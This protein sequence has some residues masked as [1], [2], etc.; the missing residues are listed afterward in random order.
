MVKFLFGAVR[1]VRWAGVVRVALYVGLVNL[2]ISYF[3]MHSAYA[4]AERSVRRLGAELTKQM[5]GELV[6]EPQAVSV[7]GQLLFLAAKETSLS[8]KAVLDRF[9]A[10]CEAHSG[11]LREQFE[12]IPGFAQRQLALPV[13]V[14]DPGRIGI[15]R[16]DAG[17]ASDTEGEAH[18]VCIAQP[19]AA[20]GVAGVVKRVQGFLAS[21]DVSQIGDMRYIA[22]RKMDDGRTQVIAIWTEGKFNIEAMFPD[23]GDVPGTDALD[24]PRPPA[25]VR[26]LSAVVPERPYAIRSYDSTL[27]ARDVLSFYDQKLNAAGWTTRPSLMD[28]NGAQLK[29]ED[30]RA[31]TRDGRALLIAATEHEPGQTSVT[32]IELG[33]LDRVVTKIATPR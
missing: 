23:R 4:D 7:N 16:S 33:T 8:V 17:S 14:R 25:A 30:A 15:I 26:R 19:D 29:P 21:G 6:G 5:G 20:G 27:A 9:D 2:G 11:G 24:I 10:N 22:A 13:S 31:F 32:T 18:L 28:D 12:K 3:L 1:R